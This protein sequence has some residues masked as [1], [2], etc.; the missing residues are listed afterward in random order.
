VGN[1]EEPR[2]LSFA[3]GFDDR[4][5]VGPDGG[6]RAFFGVDVLRGLIEGIEEHERDP[7][8]RGSRSLGPALLGSSM[9]IDD[10]EL[11]DKLEALMACIVVTKQAAISASWKS[12]S[13][14]R[15]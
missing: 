6:D 9:W 2:L 10:D 13:A 11:I 8:W 3:H 14:C 5:A 7:R 15:S 1:D 4:F 12:Y